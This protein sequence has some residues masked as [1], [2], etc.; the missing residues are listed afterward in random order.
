MFC[1]KITATDDGLFGTCAV[2]GLNQKNKYA[3]IF[4]VQKNIDK[5]NKEKT[6]DCIVIL[7]IEAK[8]DVRCLV[9][10]EHAIKKNKKLDITFQRT[11]F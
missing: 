7:K 3:I 11:E 1:F 4:I 2:K 9:E 8:C 6:I 5:K 10:S